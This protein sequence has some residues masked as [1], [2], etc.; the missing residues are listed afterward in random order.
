MQKTLNKNNRT[1][2]Q[3]WLD[4][5]LQKANKTGFLSLTLKPEGATTGDVVCFMNAKGFTA[6]VSGLTVTLAKRRVSSPE[7]AK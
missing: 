5:L 7:T 6:K 3:R 1:D 2:R 4:S